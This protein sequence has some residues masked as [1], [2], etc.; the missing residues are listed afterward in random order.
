MDARKRWRY[1]VSFS[2]ALNVF[3][4]CGAGM[5]SAGLF[6]AA[7]ME[8][9]IEVELV[10]EKS[11]PQVSASEVAQT[12]SGQTPMQSSSIASLSPNH[13]S[14][15]SSVAVQTVTALSVDEVSTEFT[16][17]HDMSG[18]Q[19]QSSAT[20]ASGA[21]SSAVSTGGQSSNGKGSGQGTGSGTGS[22]GII[23]PKI[24]SQVYPDYPESTRQAGITGTV[25]VKVQILENGR[26]GD[27]SVKQ[28]SGNSLLDESAVNAVYKW[29]FTP[30]KERNTGQAVTCY[31]TVPVSFR[32]N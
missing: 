28:S 7:P 32:L 24:L 23:G 11:N 26:A 19:E 13:P 1:A 17:N 30:A 8:Q 3:L 27:V 16:T 14:S 25:I 15:S 6:T 12:N 20:R 9:I 5:L 21:E 29:R 31:T 10:S 22:G 2:M 18:D 4:L